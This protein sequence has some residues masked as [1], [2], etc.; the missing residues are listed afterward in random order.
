LLTE[1]LG[2]PIAISSTPANGDER[3]EVEK[4]LHERKVELKNPRLRSRAMTILEA[5]RG[6]DAQWLRQKLLGQK[7]FPLIPWRK[8]GSSETKK[9]SS[10]AVKEFFQ[11][12]SS[13]WQVER[14]FS[15]IKRKC[16]R[17]MCRWER[18]QLTWV[19]FAKAS[20][21]DYWIEFLMG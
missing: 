21:I 18:K 16:R 7:I 17:I 4:L 19:A 14:A 15:W 20:L 6:Y 8:Q 12:K 10:A 13:R 3:R 1:A 5:D 11:I 2:R 9:P